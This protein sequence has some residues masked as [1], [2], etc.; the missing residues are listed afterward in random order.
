MQRSHKIKLDPNRVQETYFAKCA[1]VA[2]FTYNWGLAK[3]K[4]LYEAGERPSAMGLKKLFN[5]IK[6]EQFPFVSEVTKWAPERAFVNLDRAFSGFFK[7][8]GYPRFKKKGV[9]D[10]F[11]ISGSVIKLAGKKVKIPKLG[12][13]RMREELRFSG[14]LNSVVISK[15]ADGWS[16]SFSV[17]IPDIDSGENQVESAVGIDLGVSALATLSDGTSFQNIKTTEKYRR[18]LR[19]LNKSLSRKKKGSSNWKKAKIKLSKLHQKIANVRADHIHKMT[20]S[21][22][23]KYDCVCLE[24]LSTAGMVKNRRLAKSISDVSF[25]EITRQLEYKSKLVLKV[26]RFFP[27]TKLCR[28]CGQLHDMPLS[29]RVFECECGVGPIDRDLHAAQNILVEGIRQGL[30]DFKPV[31][32]SVL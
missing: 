19:G 14:K 17:D 20:S 30:P 12:W 3:W 10:S 7:K 5:N 8:G 27:S 15:R 1:G 32:M 9:R 22:S 16:A 31:E 29:K 28:N 4:F 21:I 23:S 18:K 25:G 2:R 24:D 26:G 13:V 6:K 11:Y